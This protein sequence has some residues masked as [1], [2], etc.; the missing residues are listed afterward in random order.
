MDAD[1][2]LYGQRQRNSTAWPIRSSG[3]YS[4]NQNLLL[5]GVHQEDQSCKKK[6]LLSHWPFDLIKYST[7]YVH[8]SLNPWMSWWNQKGQ[9]N[10]DWMIFYKIDLLNELCLM[11]V[12][13]IGIGQNID[14]MGPPILS[15][16]FRY[17]RENPRPLHHTSR[18][19]K[20][21][22]WFPSKKSKI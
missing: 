20:R 16:A 19:Y 8:L 14:L 21:K 7:T 15:Y 1:P 9:Y 17:T 6:F 3:T 12:P 10:S 18:I 13:I 22:I 2:L 11:M 5:N 4:E